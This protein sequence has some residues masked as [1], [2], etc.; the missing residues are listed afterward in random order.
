MKVYCLLYW[1][2]E[3]D[4]HLVNSFVDVKV[5][6]DEIMAVLVTENRSLLKVYLPGE[7]IPTE[8][9]GFYGYDGFYQII[10]KEV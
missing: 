4:F 5:S 2:W 10:V 1:F 7:A 9:D 3:G 8:D 6:L